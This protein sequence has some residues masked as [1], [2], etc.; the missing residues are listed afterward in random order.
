MGSFPSRLLFDKGAVV[1]W[2]PKKEPYFRGPYFR[3]LPI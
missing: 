2:G 1:Y 3:K